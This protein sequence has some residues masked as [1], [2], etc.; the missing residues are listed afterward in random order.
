MAVKP[1]GLLH[2]FPFFFYV[3]VASIVW[4]P[5]VVLCIR[6]I[7]VHSISTSKIVQFWLFF[8]SVLTEILV[9][10]E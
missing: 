10:M 9:N 6:G 7:N 8:S 5:L 4:S 3:H 2:F 1:S